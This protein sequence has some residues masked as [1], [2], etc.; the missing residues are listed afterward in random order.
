LLSNPGAES[1]VGRPEVAVPLSRLRGR[2]LRIA[3][4]GAVALALVS[5]S[6]PPGPD[7]SGDDAPAWSPLGDSIA[8]VHRAT[9]PSDRFPSGLYL[10]GIHGGPRR[11]IVDGRFVLGLDWSPDGRKIVYATF[12]GLHTVTTLGD[13]TRTLL[14]GSASFPSWSPRGDQI[15]YD[16]GRD[17]WTIPAEGG[18][19]VLVSGSLESGAR[20]PDWSADG[21]AL[22]VQTWFGRS[23][24]LAVIDLAGRVLRRVTNDPWEDRHPRWSRRRDEIAWL[25][26]RSDDRSRAGLWVVDT[27]GAGARFL[28]EGHECDWSPDGLWLV[29]SNPTEKGQRLFVRRL[30]GRTVRQITD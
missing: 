17:V 16:D 13:T 25:A 6:G 9:G 29:T 15:A 23:P 22:V 30:A 5:C 7:L 19:P 10:I 4:M 2:R 21:S 14:V 18:T 3:A 27:S 28:G 1:D 26:L 12:E 20:S 8:F 24:E 11:R